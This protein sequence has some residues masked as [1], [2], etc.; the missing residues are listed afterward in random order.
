[1]ETCHVLYCNENYSD[2]ADVTNFMCKGQEVEN[3]C[4]FELSF[5]NKA[6]EHKCLPA[7]KQL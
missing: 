6:S 4:N 7:Q 2:T 3:T 1:M 5:R